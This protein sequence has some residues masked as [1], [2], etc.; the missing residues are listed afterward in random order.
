MPTLTRGSTVTLTLDYDDVLTT[1]GTATLTITPTGGTATT[2]RVT[3]T[4]TTGAF[5][6][7]ATTVLI[8]ADTSVDYSVS[9]DPSVNGYVTSITDA[10]SGA[11]KVMAEDGS[12]R[13]VNRFTP[14]NNTYESIVAVATL[15]ASMG[16]G[17][18]ELESVNIGNNTIPLMS[19]VVYEG[20]GVKNRGAGISGGT[21][22]TG[23][24]TANAFAVPNTAVALEGCGVRNLGITNVRNG[25]YVV[26]TGTGEPHVNGF[27]E[28]VV[29]T[30]ASE[31]GFWFENFNKTTFHRLEAKG[32]LVGGLAW[33][34]TSTWNSGNS[35]ISRI[36][37]QAATIQSKTIQFIA[38][39]GNLNNIVVTGITAFAPG[40]TELQ[41]NATATNNS[42]TFR[43]LT[44]TTASLR[45]GMPIHLDPGVLHFVHSIVNSTDFKL[46]T[47]AFS[48]RSA[49]TPWTWPFSTQS[50][51]MY[52]YGFPNLILEGLQPCTFAGVD[53][54]NSS[55][56]QVYAIDCSGIIVDV[57]FAFQNTLYS[58]GALSRSVYGVNLYG[59]SKIQHR[60]AMNVYLDNSSWSTHVPSGRFSHQKGQ[61]FVSNN[62]PLLTTNLGI[63]TGLNGNGMIYLAGYSATGVPDFYINE[64]TRAIV[65]GRGVMYRQALV[66]ASSNVPAT[67]TSTYSP[68]IQV[69]NGAAGQTL[70]LPT[71]VPTGA[72]QNIGLV[73]E[74]INSTANPVTIAVAGGVQN[75]IGGA[76]KA[77]TSVL[78][79]NSCARFIACTDGTA[80]FW[81]RI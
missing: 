57:E 55:S 70:T 60:T 1:N 45:V 6:V 12:Y 42:D 54:E 39:A 58:N 65:T 35:N 40:T 5:K 63:S 64:A 69:F 68:P 10:V 28:N 17:V 53:L 51:A 4:Q 7:S 33:M 74:I 32:C 18:V 11:L 20:R 24:G 31:W 66:S 26:Y 72:T 62:D 52:T 2:K 29:V 41:F 8:S 79:A 19:G 43:M 78:A 50:K 80:P 27:F 77:N 25:L 22:I 13:A 71:I 3:G 15:A 61:G 73:Q 16:G 9:S 47:P 46:C 76:A 34:N 44:G 75:I 37:C 48:N 30:Q 67:P 23:D 56:C 21:L 38:T 36:E 59:T 81:A 14:A 49:N